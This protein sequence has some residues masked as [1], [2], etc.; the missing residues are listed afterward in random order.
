MAIIRNLRKYL[1]LKKRT[2]EKEASQAYDIW[3]SSYDEQPD[4]LML[5]LDGELFGQLLEAVNIEDKV[6]VDVGCGTGRH[7]EK[8][9]SRG[10]TQLVGYDVSDGMLKELKKKF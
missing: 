3:A 4:N 10:P 9:V 5:H 8:I 7:W 2:G 1:S 6:V